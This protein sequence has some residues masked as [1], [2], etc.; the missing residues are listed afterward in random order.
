MS[1][2]VAN[3]SME[4]VGLAPKSFYGKKPTK[5]TDRGPN[6][7]CVGGLKIILPLKK[8]GSEKNECPGVK[9]W[10]IKEIMEGRHEVG[11]TQNSSE[12]GHSRNSGEEGGAKMLAK[13]GPGRPRKVN[14]QDVIEVIETEHL[15]ISN[16]VAET[17]IST[18]Q[19]VPHSKKNGQKA[20]E[21]LGT[22]VKKARGRPRKV[23]MGDESELKENSNEVGETQRAVKKRPGRPKK[24]PLQEISEGPQNSYDEG[25]AREVLLQN[26]CGVLQNESLQISNEVPE[27]PMSPNDSS[28]LITH[29][30]NL[31]REEEGSTADGTNADNGGGDQVKKARG[32]PRKVPMK[33]KG[34][35]SEDV[36]GT[37]AVKRRPG[38]PKKVPTQDISE[39]PPN[40]DEEGGAKKSVKRGRKKNVPSHDLNEGFQHNEVDEISRSPTATS[41]N[42]AS[43][44]L[45]LTPEEIGSVFLPPTI[46][47]REPEDSVSRCITETITLDD[48][49]NG[50]QKRSSRSAPKVTNLGPDESAD[51]ASKKRATLEETYEETSNEM[52][53]SDPMTPR[54]F[55]DDGEE[56]TE[57]FRKAP[58]SPMALHL[59]EGDSDSSFEPVSRPKKKVVFNFSGSMDS[60][61]CS[62]PNFENSLRPP[63]QPTSNESSTRVTPPPPVDSSECSASRVGNS[64]RPP[65]QPTSNESS[66]G[67]TPPPPVDLGGTLNTPSPILAQSGQF[68][69]VSAL[70]N[71]ENRWHG[72]RV[73]FNMSSIL[74]STAISPIQLLQQ[75]SVQVHAGH[76]SQILVND[77][78]AIS[79][80]EM[81]AVLNRS[82]YSFNGFPTQPFV[83]QPG[84]FRSG[85]PVVPQ[86]GTFRSGQP[87]V[88]QPGTFRSGQPV[89]PQPGTFRGGPIP[90][91]PRVTAPV[92]PQ[93][94]A[95]QLG[96]VRVR[97]PVPYRGVKVLSPILTH[98][99]PTTEKQ[100]APVPRPKPR[101]AM[102]EIPRAPV[103]PVP[104]PRMQ[105][106]QET[107]VC[108]LH[109]NEEDVVIFD[110]G[111]EFEIPNESEQQQPIPVPATRGLNAQN[112]KRSRNPQTVQA[113]RSTYTNRSSGSANAESGLVNDTYAVETSKA[114]YSALD[115]T[116]TYES[117]SDNDSDSD[118]DPNQESLANPNAVDDDADS[119]DICP[120]ELFK[121][122]PTLK[123]G[124]ATKTGY[125]LCKD[126]YLFHM[127][128]KYEKKN[129]PGE[130]TISWRCV[131]YRS[132]H[133]KVRLST[134]FLMTAIIKPS[135]MGH[136]HGDEEERI[137]IK[138]F[139]NGCCISAVET[140]A[141]PRTI[142]DQRTE[143]ARDKDVLSKLPAY[144]SIAKSMRRARNKQDNIPGQPK[145]LAEIVLPDKYK[146]LASGE[147]FLMYDSGP[148]TG[149]KRIFIFSTPLNLSM[150]QNESTWYA[151]G[152]FK[153]TP[154]HFYQV[155]TVHAF[156]EGQ[157]VPL[158]YALMPNKNARGYRTVLKKIKYWHQGSEPKEIM[159]D[160]ETGM[161]TAVKD[162]YPNTR[163]RG[164]FFHF[165]QACTKKITENA[166]NRRKF[167]KD[168]GFAD[169]V[170][171]LMALALVKPDKVATYFEV[172]VLKK[173]IPEE[174]RDYLE[175]FERNY[176]GEKD[177]DFPGGRRPPTFKL[178]MWNCHDLAANAEPKTN[179][180]MEG[181]HRHFHEQFQYSHPNIFKFIKAIKTHQA[182]NYARISRRMVQGPD[183]DRRKSQ[184]ERELKL[185]DA[186]V[187]YPQHERP[188]GSQEERN[189]IT[190]Q[191]VKNILKYIRKLSFF[192]GVRR[193][194]RQRLN[195]SNLSID[196]SRNLSIH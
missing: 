76:G 112:R 132:C 154:Q 34:E 78:L 2:T 158:V 4:S 86:P 192:I 175:Y 108:Q 18:D 72:N 27:T 136:S 155:Y 143:A 186:V 101:N 83:P 62:V 148:E 114:E 37:Q 169:A 138:E 53:I 73:N 92:L 176:I 167:E 137:L 20:A 140:L 181:W 24:A 95:S 81:A 49:V 45:N 103:P 84:T 87:V 120:E 189:A 69:P 64:L 26:L 59:S 25:T 77:S 142:Y 35:N 99:H 102:N 145:S 185:S 13:V 135:E 168:R 106:R 159:T 187:N 23:P 109:G 193:R 52:T 180:S 126:G 22:T 194:K 31:N 88:P 66:T 128:K 71:G 144:A 171:S 82:I 38:R 184:V 48:C 30:L 21:K 8:K 105:M 157:S 12:D 134:N 79:S 152:T 19:S 190:E 90:E 93:R 117:E 40:N 57:A 10:S 42:L 100:D 162:V 28:D 60:S 191:N 47:K 104:K 67:G 131:R 177:A 36:G 122:I 139:M 147:R 58:E 179:N 9:L 46:I 160:F 166:A 5:R 118:V 165:I 74:N 129:S 196:A 161:K 141:R 163:H 29:L 110:V 195:N 54:H 130:G 153:S 56:E 119:T 14:P 156:I 41:I 68:L 55:S 98:I 124:K 65:Y 1:E 183:A 133:C 50:P 91:Q 172:I 11:G 125:Y 151:D 170:K 75:H 94:N 63:C 173:I 96:G 43:D 149:E 121:L 146:F 113:K 17:P 182:G 32:R 39:A 178:S 107:P 70:E 16:E 80:F 61:E 174:A 164:C 111:N 44:F 7:D 33:E 15:Q 188:R 3:E 97:Q 89:F 115:N 51:N 6:E 123:K 85:Q 127:E 150:L 116:E